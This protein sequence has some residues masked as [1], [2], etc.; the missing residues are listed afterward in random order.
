MKTKSI[1]LA[2]VMAFGS[3]AAIAADPVGPKLVVVSQKDP[4]TFKVIYEGLQTSKLTLRI[5]DSEGQ[6]V[7][8]E[9]ISGVESF[10]RTVN[11]AGMT[12]GEYTIEVAGANGKQTQKVSYQPVTDESA[13]HISKLAAD[14]KYLLAVANAKEVNVK[15]YDGFN[16]LVHDQN[17]AVNGSIGLVYDLSKISGSPKFEVS[18]ATGTKVVNY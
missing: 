9:T 3:V 2:F 8:T 13:I 11:F 12:A 7:A 14:S 4:A 5:L 18:T 16:T 10:M 15:I 6:K 1:V 17:V